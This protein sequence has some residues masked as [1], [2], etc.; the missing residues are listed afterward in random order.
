MLD[1]S[2]ISGDDF[3]G[4]HLKGTISQMLLLVLVVSGVCRR[5]IIY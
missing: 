5:L 4:P 1:W 2:T 3:Q